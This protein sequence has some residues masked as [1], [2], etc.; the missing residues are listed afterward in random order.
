MAAAGLQPGQLSMELN[1]NDSRH[2]IVEERKIIINLI[3]FAIGLME[4]LHEMNRNT[5]QDLKL[6]IG[7]AVGPVIA[8]IVGK[9]KPQ[10]DI[11]GDTV[12]VASRM[13]STGVLGR[14]QITEE[15]ANIIFTDDDY[16]NIFTL[17][18]RG[19]IPVKGKGKLI[20]YIAKTKFDFD[21]PEIN[22]SIL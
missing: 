19:P 5:F 3:C 16:E 4:K 21:E 17:E 12:N 2:S 13:E 6:R 14:I 9:S 20:T 8:G 7:I 10:Y 1:N 11:W 18:K 22:E 15:T